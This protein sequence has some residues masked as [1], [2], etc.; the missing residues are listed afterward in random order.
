[1]ALPLISPD[2][3]PAGSSLSPV[4]PGRAVVVAPYGSGRHY[5]SEFA[6]RGWDCVA[7]T[8]AD[9]ALPPLY[10]GSLDP[11]GYR[12]VVVHDGNVDETARAL[13][14]LRVRAVVAGTEIGVPLAEQLAYR[15]GLPGN[16]PQT[17]HRRRDKGAMAAAL[18]S[19]GIDAPRS[20]STDR[21]R[22]ALSWAH[23][24]DTPDLVLKWLTPPDQTA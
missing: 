12:R 11:T 10:R 5:Q 15:L 24:L 6:D 17:S 18:T 22:D 14:A 1:M 23:S 9:D 16:D 2:R 3:T 8:P 7:V 20:L 4:L 19:A 13:R 21:L